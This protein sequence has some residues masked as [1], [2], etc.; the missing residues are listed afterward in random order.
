MLSNTMKHGE[1]SATAS[2]LSAVK[3][4]KLGS[5]LMNDLKELRS[6]KVFGGSSRLYDSLNNILYL[7]IHATISNFTVGISSF[8]TLFIVNVVPGAYSILKLFPQFNSID[9]F[10][11]LL[12]DD[13]IATA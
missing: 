11:F 6:R 4:W 8:E 2:K 1:T 7:W 13:R 5:E 9:T 3:M 10:Y 12:V